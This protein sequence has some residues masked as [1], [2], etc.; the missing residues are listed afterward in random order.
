MSMP[1][2]KW[3]FI[4]DAY[5]GDEYVDLVGLDIY[6]GAGQESSVWRSFRKE[7]IENYFM[8]TDRLPGK[9][10]LVCETA[11]RE[12]GAGEGEGQ[13]KAQWIAQLSEALQ[14]D[15]RAIKLLAW[16]NEKSTFK[17]NSSPSSKKAY[18]DH[19]V[20]DGYFRSSNQPLLSQFK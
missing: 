18:Q 14:S 20:K 6:N 7:G 17:I 2:E 1:Q 9:P 10:L 8:L 16:F 15:M 12:R 4:M 13:T 19:I 11:S 3:N 5:P